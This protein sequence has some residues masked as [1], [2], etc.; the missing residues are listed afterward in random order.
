MDGLL[1][2]S[3][4]DGNFVLRCYGVPGEKVALITYGLDQSPAFKGP[5]QCQP[6]RSMIFYGQYTARKGTLVLEEILPRVAY[7][8]TD[9]HLTF[10]VQQ[11]AVERV[12]TKFGSFGDRL[13]VHEWMPRRDALDLCRKHQI[14]L[15]PSMLEGFGKTFLE[16][17]AC[18]LCVV[19]YREG[20]LPDLAVNGIEALYC[21]RGNVAE[22]ERLLMRA[23]SDPELARRIGEAARRKALTYSW[24]N[25]A[26]EIEGFC[27]Q[28]LEQ[29]A[30]RE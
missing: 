29:K 19:G 25:T 9:A 28:R 18:G 30:S 14:F 10:I 16:A 20:G 23:L 1:A 2:P 5:S 11:E 15:F 27:L 26:R 21:E 17:M 13:H 8:Y 4:G 12:R 24:E 6:V 7:R 22:L 3:T